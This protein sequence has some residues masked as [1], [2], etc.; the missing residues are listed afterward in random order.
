[1]N[2]ESK[3][4]EDILREMREYADQ[5]DND[6]DITGADFRDFAN[7]LEEAMKREK[8]VT[9]A[10]LACKGKM[11]PHHDPEHAPPPYP[12]N[13]AKLREALKA[14]RDYF[15]ALR[16]KVPGSLSEQY[17]T[18][19]IADIDV[20]LAA[21]TRNCDVGT[22]NEQARRFQLFCQNHRDIDTECSMMCPFVDT[23]DI[24]HC[25]SGWAQL[26]YK[27]EETRKK[28]EGAK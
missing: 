24:N 14:S 10:M 19:R 28:E 11:T 15:V 20:A 1:M 23:A 9:D 3:T 22:P 6:G 26:P 12:G 7:Q 21:P 8:A 16:E 4:T 27:E 13:A 18:R 25:Q 17:L 5:L 2:S